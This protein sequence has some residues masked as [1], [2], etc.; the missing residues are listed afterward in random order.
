SAHRRDYSGVHFILVDDVRTTGASI[1][2]AARLLRAL[3]PAKII[4]AVLAVSD[5]RARELRRAHA[6]SAPDH[7]G[8][9]R[10]VN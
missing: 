10:S 2:A 7:T 4:A 5:A 1:R 6:P 9:F 3:K 8:D